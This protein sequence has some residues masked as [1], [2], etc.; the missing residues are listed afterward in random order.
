MDKSVSIFSTFF[1]ISVII[2]GRKENEVSDMFLVLE[3]KKY[4]ERSRNKSRLAIIA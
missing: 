3:C 2:S 1:L 4:L